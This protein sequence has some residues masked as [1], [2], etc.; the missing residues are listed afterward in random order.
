MR[1]SEDGRGQESVNDAFDPLL[2]LGWGW[3][4]GLLG[5]RGLEDRSEGQA[6]GEKIFHGASRSALQDMAEF[7]PAHRPGT[8]SSYRRIFK[9]LFAPFCPVTSTERS[10]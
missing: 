2:D 8:F 4:V 9:T 5:R 3:R 7:R 10:R 6:D 1:I